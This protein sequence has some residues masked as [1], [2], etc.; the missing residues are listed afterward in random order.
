[1]VTQYVIYKIVDLCAQNNLG[2]NQQDVRV[3]KA[4]VQDFAEKNA[5]TQEKSNVLLGDCGFTSRW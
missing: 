5:I 3:I 1:M 2:Y 4:A